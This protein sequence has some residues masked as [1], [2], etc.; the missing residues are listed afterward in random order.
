MA[1]IV[2]PQHPIYLTSLLVR[3]VPVLR[4]NVVPTAK[5]VAFK[6][7]MAILWPF[8]TPPATYGWLAMARMVPHH[9]LIYVTSLLV[10]FAPVICI[11]VVPAAKKVARKAKKR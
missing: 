7:K 11:N 10:Q 5:K 6:T 8:W 1:R 4:M 9:H 2:P 3:S